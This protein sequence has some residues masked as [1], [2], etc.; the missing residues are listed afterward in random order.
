M[1][2]PVTEPVIAPDGQLG[3]LPDG[4][5]LYDPTER[6]TGFERLKRFIS[7]FTRATPYASDSL[8]GGATMNWCIGGDRLWR[9][10]CCATVGGY[11]KYRVYTLQADGR[12]VEIQI[13]DV[14]DGRGWLGYDL[15]G[16]MCYSSWQG[17]WFK[18]A[19]G[20]MRVPTV[21]PIPLGSG[22]TSP[23]P[24]PTASGSGILVPLSPARYT[25]AVNGQ[26]FTGSQYIDLV[27]LFGLPGPIM[28]LDVRFTMTGNAQ[29]VRARLGGDGDPWQITPTTQI[30]NQ[31]MSDRGLIYP[32]DGRRVLMSLVPETASALL[33]LNALGYF[34]Q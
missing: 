11:F 33:W 17:S 24:P 4:H 2:E 25:P 10:G 21:P 6:V 23:T 19:G 26:S 7:H 20:P 5:T 30:G 15:E 31:S 1:T 32:M 8:Y 29:D 3:Q 9:L 28:A 16:Y 22:G 34:T 14:G 18:P 13:T 12:L 27:Q